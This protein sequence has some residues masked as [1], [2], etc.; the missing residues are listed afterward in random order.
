M[1][2]DAYDEV[3]NPW[4]SP[5][6]NTCRPFWK[7]LAAGWSSYYVENPSAPASEERSSIMDATS[8]AYKTRMAA[9]CTSVN[10]W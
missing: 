1:S 10:F 9:V 8:G 7:V 4:G 3:K 6:H 2:L 5:F